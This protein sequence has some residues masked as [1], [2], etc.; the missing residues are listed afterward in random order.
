MQ[1]KN[2][3]FSE[4]KSVKEVFAEHFSIMLKNPPIADAKK[5]PKSLG[6]KSANL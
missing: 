5:S 6:K 4:E 2:Y 1:V 3:I